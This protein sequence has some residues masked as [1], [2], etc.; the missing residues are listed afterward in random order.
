MNPT[1]ILAAIL[2]VI[3]TF[4]IGFSSGRH[5]GIVD[6]KAVDQVQFDK[7]NRDTAEQK[8]Q[9]NALY[10]KKQ[11]DNLALMLERDQLKTRLEKQHATNQANTA[12]LRDK[13]T[14]LGLHFTAEAPRLGNGSRCA[15]SPGA[16]PA[17]NE[18]AAVVQLPGEIA[19]NLRRLA[20]DAD[21]LADDY[22]KCYGYV[23]QVR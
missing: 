2:A 16:D 1:L 21:S 5:A 18:P 10:R 8:T 23:E 4:G 15:P 14:G 12:A 11:D 13:Y 19:E 3:A 9:A 22:R 20:F 7:I 6:Q 17:S